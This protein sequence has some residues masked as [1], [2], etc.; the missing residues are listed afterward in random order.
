[1]AA[2]MLHGPMTALGAHFKPNGRHIAA[3]LTTLSYGSGTTTVTNAFGVADTYT[4]RP[5]RAF[6]K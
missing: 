3:N 1:M 2:A 5:C 6:Q 4:F